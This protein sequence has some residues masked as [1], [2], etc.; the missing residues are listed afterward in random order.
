MSYSSLTDFIGDLEKRGELHRIKAFVDPVLEITEVT[1]RVTNQGAKPLLLFENNG[2]S[3]PL[4]INAFGSAKRM[5]L[6]LG[7]DDLAGTAKEIQDLIDILMQRAFHII[8]EI[9][10][11]AKDC[12]NG[13]PDACQDKRERFLPEGNPP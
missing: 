6:A 4:L 12:R 3:F 2:T 13:I 1:D 5:A 11:S 9:V 7:K 8:R 10:G